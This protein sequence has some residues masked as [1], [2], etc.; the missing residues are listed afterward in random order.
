MISRW[1]AITSTAVSIRRSARTARSI[2]RSALAAWS[3][4]AFALARYLGAFSPE[5]A[6]QQLAADVNALV[7]AGALHADE[8]EDLTARLNKALRLLDGGDA[9]KAVK[10]LNDFSRQVNDLVNDGRLTL[11]QGR[12]LT[13]RASE[14]ARRISQ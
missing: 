3:T 7:N 6:I 5:A 9:G 1:R 14:I 12:A 4:E 2:R 10:A 8:G 13:D 11:S